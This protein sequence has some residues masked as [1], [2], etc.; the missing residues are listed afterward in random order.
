MEQNMIL[1]GISIQELLTEFE[2]RIRQVVRQE[3]TSSE[4]SDPK[5]ADGV[6]YLSRKEVATSLGVSIPTLKNWTIDGKIKAYRIGRRVLYH[7]DDVK[8]ALSKINTTK[9]G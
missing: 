6:Q 5:P 3:I 1:T 2:S 4:Q 7:P 9:G 8:G